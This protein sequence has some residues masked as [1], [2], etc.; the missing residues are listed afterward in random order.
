MIN[1]YFAEREAIEEQFKDIWQNKTPIIF[2]NSRQKLPRTGSVVR[3]RIIGED[4]TQKSIGT[5][6]IHRNIGQVFAEI[7]V[8]RGT[9]LDIVYN[10]A[11]LAQSAFNIIQ[12]DSI[13][14]R[15]AYQIIVGEVGDDWFQ[16]NVIAPFYRNSLVDM[17]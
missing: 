6:Q 13:Q 16:I 15:S 12:L 11:D 2:E 3:L 7:S 1:T 14:F 8:K 17:P 5:S 9:G 4:K 10:L